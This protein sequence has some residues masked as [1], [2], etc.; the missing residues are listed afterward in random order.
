MKKHLFCIISFILF[1]LVFVYFLVIFL[2]GYFIEKSL[3]E[4][5]SYINKDNKSPAVRFEYTS[6]E[7][8]LF[9]REGYIKLTSKLF[10]DSKVPFT[11][12]IGFFKVDAAL[13]L[14][15]LVTNANKLIADDFDAKT[16]KSNLT[17]DIDVLKFTA[18]L[19]AKLKASYKAKN[20]KPVS[21]DIKAYA[22]SE[23]KPSLTVAVDNYNYSKLLNLG[24]ARFEGNIE[25]L[26]KITSLGKGELNAE[27]IKLNA[28][29][30]DSV[31]LDYKAGLCD[32]DNNFK[33]TVDAEIKNLLG[34]LSTVEL[35]SE[36]TSLNL[37]KITGA[38]SAS[39]GLSY[40]DYVLSDL[41]RA[42]VKK[43]EF[44]V[45]NKQALK[46]FNSTLDAAKFNAEGPL[47]FKYPD[48]KNTLSGKLE[49]GTNSNGKALSLFMKKGK[50]GVY[51]TELLIINGQYNLGGIPLG[52][53][54]IS[55]GGAEKILEKIPMSEKTQNKVNK[56]LDVIKL[57]PAIKLK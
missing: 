25:G 21:I 46:L 24:K 4:L 26:Y 2:T 32:K 18:E 11:S 36:L 48:I 41:K 30:I 27:K 53:G 22:D 23:E 3:S 39:N 47:A 33:V 9:K 52:A 42:Y 54:F 17:A 56:A 12:D 29:E 35:T 49:I 57:L 10:L 20:T 40:A 13:D 19:K 6:T 51:R 31:E 16:V 28:G 50:D 14:A 37:D 55:G 34:Y 44:T 15:E 43:A 5:D 45:S 7:S 1:I 38:R 8:S